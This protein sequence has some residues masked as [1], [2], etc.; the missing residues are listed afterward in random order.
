M[1]K[2]LV[3]NLKLS[4]T[5]RM[6]EISKELESQGKDLFKFGFGQSPFQVPEDVVSELKNNAFQNKYL[7]MQGLPELREAI[8][9]FVSKKKKYHYK[10]DNI[11]IGPGTKELMF[12]LQIL[13]DGEVLL[14]S[15]SWVSYEPQAILGRNKVHWIETT[16]EKNWFPTASD[17]EKIISKNKKKKLFIIFKLS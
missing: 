10:A 5:L 14:P 4:A 11:L 13:F 1:I 6:N 17:I 7:P 16:R 15:P 2:D 3:K 8:A 9:N 12:L